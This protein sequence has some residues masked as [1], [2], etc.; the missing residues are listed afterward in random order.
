MSEERTTTHETPVAERT[1]IIHDQPSRDGGGAVWIFGIV[2]LIA[3]L[4]AVYFLATRSDSEA[5]KD[6]AVAG[7]AEQVGDAAQ[8]VGNAAETA[9]DNMGA[10]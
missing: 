7:A 5:V 1:T 3:V 9:A 4:A 10:K 6:N 2:L 8:K